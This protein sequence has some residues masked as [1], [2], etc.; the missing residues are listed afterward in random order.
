[1]SESAVVTPQVRRALAR[2]GPWLARMVGNDVGKGL[3]S[4]WANRTTLV[5]ELAVLVAYYIL[6]QFLI[7]GGRLMQALLPPP[8]SASPST[9]SPTS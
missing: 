4:L 5:P 8:C 9:P 6:V 2:P 7:G 1:M 3:L